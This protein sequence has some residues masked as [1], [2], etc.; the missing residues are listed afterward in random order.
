M[1]DTN[2]VSFGHVP[3]VMNASM[4][5]MTQQLYVINEL[6]LQCYKSLVKK[7]TAKSQLQYLRNGSH[8]HEE[9]RYTNSIS[10]LFI[11]WLIV[12]IPLMVSTVRLPSIVSYVTELTCENRKDNTLFMIS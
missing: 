1:H 3:V 4:M 2:L 9:N 5:T 11:C 8:V 10:L 12:Q 6:L 7:Q